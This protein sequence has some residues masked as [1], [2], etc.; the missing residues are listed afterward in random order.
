M[1]VITLASIIVLS[2]AIGGFFGRFLSNKKNVFS[3]NYVEN[4]S[5]IQI[6][7]NEKP[8]LITPLLLDKGQLALHARLFEQYSENFAIMI[9]LSSKQID[10]ALPRYSIPFTIICAKTTKPVLCVLFAKQSIFNDPNSLELANI[11]NGLSALELQY[12]VV[13]DLPNINLN[14]IIDKIDSKMYPE[15]IF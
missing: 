13:P 5:A 15:S 9:Q 7:Q 10:N 12:I 2:I 14:E 1:G 3:S 6:E 4:V 8:Q 11:T